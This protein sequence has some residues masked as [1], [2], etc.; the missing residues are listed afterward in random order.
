M[1]N[2]WEF[3]CLNIADSDQCD[4]AKLTHPGEM[5]QC[6]V[7]VKKSK[8]GQAQPE[9]PEEKKEKSLLQQRLAYRDRVI[10]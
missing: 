6:C 10:L 3:C 4:A 7:N 8:I 1:R 9:D 2:S 5:Y